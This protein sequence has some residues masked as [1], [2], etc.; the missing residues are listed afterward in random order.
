MLPPPKFPKRACWSFYFNQ[1][2]EIMYFLA[3]TEAMNEHDS[4]DA[5]ANKDYVHS[6]FFRGSIE[7]PENAIF[8]DLHNGKRFA[9]DIGE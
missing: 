4:L 5:N 6:S 9:L 2:D 7:L 8:K 1:I 3:M